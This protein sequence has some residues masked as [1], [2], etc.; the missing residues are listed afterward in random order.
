MFFHKKYEVSNNTNKSELNLHI[1]MIRWLCFAI[2][3]IKYILKY[4][5]IVVKTVFLIQ[6][7][8]FDK[9]KV[10][11]DFFQKTFD[12]FFFVFYLTNPFETD[13]VEAH[14]LVRNIVNQTH[15]Y[16]M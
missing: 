3:W 6:F 2:T 15:T 8:M 10:W 14:N 7:L 9:K 1:R 13:Q 5:Y 12:W 11:W 4:F 16:A